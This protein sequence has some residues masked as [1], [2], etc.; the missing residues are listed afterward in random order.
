MSIPQPSGPG[1]QPRVWGRIPQRNKNFTGRDD[2]LDK[3]H[4][5]VTSE[6]TAV[7]PHALHGFGGVGK[8]QVAIEYAWRFRHEYDVVWWIPADQ[9]MLIRSALAG[10]APHLGLPS[11]AATSVV[12]AS[13]AVLDALRRG[14][15]YSRW[16]LIF[17]NADEPED[18]N[19]LVPRGPGHVLITSRNFAWQSVVDTVPVDVF[20]R[21]ESVQFLKKRVAASIAEPEAS[22]LAE[23]LGDLP[24]ALEQAGALQ[25]ETGMSVDTYL[26]LLAKQAARLLDANKPADYPLSMTAA[27]SL[28]VAQLES[29]LP[30]AVELLKCCAFFGPESIPRDVFGELPPALAGQSRLQP[31]LSDTILLSKAIRMLGRYALI[32]IEST[33]RTITLHRLVQALMRA[34]LSEEDRAAFRHEV[35]LL[36]AAFAPQSS[37]DVT[38]WPRYSELLVHVTPAR[39]EV[40]LDPGIRRFALG[41]TRYLYSSGDVHVARTLA[42][43]FVARWRADSGDDDIHVMTMRRHLGNIL[44]ALGS[45]PEAYELNKWNLARMRELLGPDHEETQALANAHGADLRARGEF[46]EAL[47]HDEELFSQ[48]RSAFGPEHRRTLRV[49]N[50]LSVDHLLLADYGRARELQEAV[51]RRLRRPETGSSQIELVI[52]WN[53]LA[54]VLRLSGEYSEACD[55]GED[56]HEFGVNELGAEHPWTLKTAKDLS[57]AKRRAGLI[58]EALEIAQVTHEREQRLFGRDHPDTLAA[59]L[60]L[61]NALRTQGR[62]ED[63]LDLLRDAAARY[64]A[65]FGDDHPFRYGC[66]MNL[67]LLL[68]VNDQASEALT[69]DRSALDGFD[70]KLGRDHHYSLT[71]AINLAS[72]LASVGDAESA[73]RLGENT[74]ERL[75]VLLGSDH[76]LTLAGAANLV[77]DLRSTGDDDQADALA[78]D[79]FDRYQRALGSDHPD[80][81]VA[82]NGQRL[83][84]DFDPPAL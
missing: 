80:V 84:F 76:P 51:F 18:I 55:V 40:C 6:V 53:G 26:D 83:D 77:I 20:S 62:I 25:A 10:L 35:H 69:L 36:L 68:R 46:V 37:D 11:S 66:D 45:Y 7:L 79:T 72:D 31:I 19:E 32:R 28:S 64:P 61:A 14:E 8:T 73:R 23:E 65:T 70:A 13:E 60:C 74:L 47:R 38:T 29:R 42:E 59:A 67:A 58:D 48:H 33:G 82:L 17:D 54:R 44:W 43:R 63:A 2:L 39:V 71:C 81:I 21:E 30:E 9:L 5:G 75:R 4:Q 15:P 12:D 16:L 27:W 56:A 50:N 34:E 57:I 78:E 22:R 1:P 49:Q 24:L 3:V 41:V 52:S